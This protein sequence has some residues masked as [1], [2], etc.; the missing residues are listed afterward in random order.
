MGRGQSRQPLPPLLAALEQTERGEAGGRA[1]QPG[2]EGGALHCGLSAWYGETGSGAQART[3]RL[4]PSRPPRNSAHTPSSEML[5]CCGSLVRVEVGIRVRVRVR[6]RVGVGVWVELLRQPGRIEPLERGT[7]RLLPQQKQHAVQRQVQ[8]LIFAH[9]PLVRRQH[10]VQHLAQEHS[11]AA[12]LTR[13]A[14]H[15][16]RSAQPAHSK[17]SEHE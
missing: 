14:A 5:S 13:P 3:H 16:C 8:Q 9:V 4:P 12:V 11:V 15:L 1:G 7:V 10:L 17:R 2:G 6:V